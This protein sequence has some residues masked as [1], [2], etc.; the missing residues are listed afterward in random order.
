MKKPV[1]AICEKKK[2]Q[3]SLRIRASDQHLCCLLSSSIKYLVSML[4]IS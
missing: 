1:F 3:I 4:A 2:V